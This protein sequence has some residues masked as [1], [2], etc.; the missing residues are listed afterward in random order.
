MKTQDFR[1]RVQR[2]RTEVIERLTH[3]ARAHSYASGE[4]V[5]DLSGEK[6]ISYGD[7]NGLTWDGWRVVGVSLRGMHIWGI[8]YPKGHIMNFNDLT[9]EQLID[10]LEAVEKV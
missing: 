6:T 1:T 5:I 2:I 10:T 8:L 3:E 9:T 7:E 4:S